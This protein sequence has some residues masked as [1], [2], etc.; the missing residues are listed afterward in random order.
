M[1]AKARVLG[2]QRQFRPAFATIDRALQINPRSKLALVV[3]S[4][5]LA[6]QWKFNKDTKFLTQ[7]IQL[8]DSVLQLTPDYVYALTSK[9][10]H[11]MY[12]GRYDDGLD[13]A[14]RAVEIHPNSILTQATLSACY[15]AIHDFSE[16]MRIAE[17]L[18]A[19]SPNDFRGWMARGAIY[20]EMGQRARSRA[21]WMQAAKV[22]PENPDLIAEARGI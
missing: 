6:E 20:S 18:I 3:K 13:V 15:T 14:L 21:D 12:T 9:S 7:G 16:A 5:I 2:G 22:N 1:C 10:R 11:L 8:C 4:N 19:Q 17:H